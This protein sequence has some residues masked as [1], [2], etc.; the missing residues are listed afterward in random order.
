LHNKFEKL[1]SLCV[2]IIIHAVHVKASYATSMNV[3]ANHTVFVMRVPLIVLD[4][5][6]MSAVMYMAYVVVVA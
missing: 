4:L 5:V 3:S 2:I 6:S 1:R